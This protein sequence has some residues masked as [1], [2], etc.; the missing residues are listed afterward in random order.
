MNPRKK[1]MLAALAAVPLAVGLTGC[2][3]D[4]SGEVVYDC[5][6]EQTPGGDYVVLDPADCD[7]DGQNYAGSHGGIMPW[8]FYH[9]GSTVYDTG[10]SV[11]RA[12]VGATSL[13]AANNTAAKS[14]ALNNTAKATGLKVGSNGV[15][16]GAKGGFG[17]SGKSGGSVGG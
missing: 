4:Q 5:V 17:F 9:G 15:S 16:S 13:A 12:A 7:N 3:A 1:A 2:A 8:I 10:S 6:V 11:P 14:T